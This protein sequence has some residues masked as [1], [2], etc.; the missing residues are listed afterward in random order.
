VDPMES[1]D[2]SSARVVEL[3]GQLIRP[4][5]ALPT[6]RTDWNVRDLVGHLIGGMLGYTRMLTAPQPLS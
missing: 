6:P 4:Q 5:W 1:L 3:V 2:A